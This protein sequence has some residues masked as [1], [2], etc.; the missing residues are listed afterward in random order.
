[1]IMSVL[2]CCEMRGVL[3]KVRINNGWNLM[4][5][6]RHSSWLS[7]QN[8]LILILDLGTKLMTHVHLS[9]LLSSS[10]GWLINVKHSI[11]YQ[12]VGYLPRVDSALWLLTS[13]QQPLK[14]K[15]RS[16]FIC[17]L[18]WYV[19]R[20]RKECTCAWWHT[21]FFK[22]ISSRYINSNEK[23]LNLEEQRYLKSRNL[24]L[25][26]TFS[27]CYVLTTVDLWPS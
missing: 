13:P 4:I 21:R 12:G 8:A 17:S 15:S 7:P 10:T 27:C 6:S 18:A 14:N 25:T 19:L 23:L 22:K 1:M 20:Y 9:A 3:M 2:K 11:I 5:H 16:R 24:I 26:L